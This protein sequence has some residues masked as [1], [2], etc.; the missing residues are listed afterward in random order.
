MHP[1]IC[2]LGPVT[3]YSYGLMLVIAFV[4]S[5]FL[6]AAQAKREKIDPEIIF[7][8]SFTIFISGIIGARIFYV[9]DNL[10]Y[11]LKAP[12]E[13]IMLQKGG[14]AWFGG[15]ILG[16]ICGILYI[17]RKNLPVYKIID[18]FAPF[19]A[20][21]QAIGRIGCFLNG[22]CYGK[23]SAFGIY[24][25]AQGAVLIPSQ[26]YSALI[27]VVIF[28]ILRIMQVRPHKNGEIFFAY[29]FFYSIKRFFVEYL[30]A[31]NP[32]IIFGLTLFQILSIA[33]FI[34]AAIYLYIIKKRKG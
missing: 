31:D 18:L 1:E 33:V 16:S 12:L 25:P 5:T 15:L 3:V 34:L 32:V 30:R 8:L 22:C 14:L 4:V 29:L 11:Y 27:L 7:N 20:F 28:V 23:E 2:K 6:A 10:N 9:L 17:K 21:G 24:S 19:V 26:L 13:I